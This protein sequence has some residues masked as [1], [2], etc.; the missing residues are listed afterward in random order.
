[1]EWPLKATAVWEDVGSGCLLQL[2]RMRDSRTQRAKT[3]SRNGGIFRQR[4]TC[5]S[6]FEAEKRA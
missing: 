2:V 5:L 3:R 6:I 1:M 4:K